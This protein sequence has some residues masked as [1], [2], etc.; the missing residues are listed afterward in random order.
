MLIQDDGIGFTVDH[1]LN[2]QHSNR[3]GLLGMRERVEMINGNF[4]VKSEVGKGTLV[5]VE[6][7][8]ESSKLK[9]PHAAKS[10][11]SDIECP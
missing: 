1:M 8:R 5:R 11:K 3:L 4:C 6:I 9:K 2:T 10:T 7:P